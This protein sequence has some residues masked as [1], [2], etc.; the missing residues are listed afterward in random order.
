MTIQESIIN[1]V[2]YA[3]QLK[4]E[5]EKLLE[6]TK[7]L[8]IIKK[9]GDIKLTGSFS[10]DLMTWRDIDICL[11]INELSKDNVFSIA[12]EIGKIDSVGSIYYRNEYVMRTEGN[13]LAIFLCIELFLKDNIKWK[14]DILISSE[15]V[16]N[17]VIDKSK[18]IT[19]KLNDSYR[20]SILEIKYELTNL[21]E[22]RQTIKSTDIYDAVLNHNVKDIEEWNMWWKSKV[23]QR[24]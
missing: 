10:Y 24:S 8:N 18:F 1:P 22:Y 7:I 11:I 6:K 17:S 14:I 9:F 15:Q 20:K 5:A 3:S 13:P 21:S 2:E 16:V 4:F 19:D 23:D 12:S